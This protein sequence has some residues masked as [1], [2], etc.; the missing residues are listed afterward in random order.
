MKIALV[1]TGLMR[2][3]VEGCEAFKKFVLEPYGETIDVH[4]HTWSEIGFYTGKGFKKRGDDGFVRTT[5]DDKGFYED[6][7]QI[8]V[9]HIQNLYHPWIRT[10]EVEDWSGGMEP[11]FDDLKKDFPNAYTRPKNTLAQFYK[12]WMGMKRVQEY[13]VQNN[14]EYDFIFRTRPDFIIQSDFPQM[15]DAEIFYVNP[16]Q[17]SEKIGFGDQFHASGYANMLAFSELFLNV[18]EL[19]KA[20]GYSCPHAYTQTWLNWLNFPIEILKMNSTIMHS[21]TGIYCEPDL[22]RPLEEGELDPE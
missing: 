18:D 2:C 5:N 21:P 19:Y 15:W 16:G 6:G 3:Y 8:D 13:A 11:H 17:N 22:G 14:V 12:V 20:I 7:E 9:T 4:I 10:I 1:L